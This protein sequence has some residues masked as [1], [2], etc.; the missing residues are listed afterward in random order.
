MGQPHS[1]LFGI[2]IKEISRI[3][4]VSVKTA[5]RWK[6][7]QIVPPHTAIL[8]LRLLWGGDLS[9]L[10]PEWRDWHYHEGTLVSPDGWRIT[11][12]DALAVPLME[13]HIQA[14]R[15]KLADLESTHD[16]LEEQPEPG[17]IPAILTG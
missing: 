7:G 2:P 12:N 6:A 11:R 8:T 4:S 13:G 3:C 17:D 1:E 16:A 5:Q 9:V 14:L 15:A 10:G